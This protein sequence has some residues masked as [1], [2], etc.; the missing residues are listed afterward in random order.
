MIGIVNRS[1]RTPGARTPPRTSGKATIVPTIEAMIVTTTAIST[2]VRSA[3]WI[4]VSAA[5]T[6]YQCRV[7]PVIGRPGV[8][9]SSN[10]KRTRNAIGR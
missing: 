7:S 6:W 9:A 3:C 5:S 1:R 2:E 4:D 10:E 8:A